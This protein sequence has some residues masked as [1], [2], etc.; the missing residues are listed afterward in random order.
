[1]CKVKVV[2][3]WEISYLPIRSLP[4]LMSPWCLHLCCYQLM[5]P[6]PERGAALNQSAGPT[7]G[8]EGICGQWETLAG[9]VAGGHRAPVC[10]LIWVYIRLWENLNMVMEYIMPADLL[11]ATSVGTKEACRWSVKAICNWVGS[12][13]SKNG[14]SRKTTKI[15]VEEYSPKV[16]ALRQWGRRRTR[17][18]EGRS[19]VHWIPHKPIS[20]STTPPEGEDP[21]HSAVC[22]ELFFLSGGN[23]WHRTVRHQFF[24]TCCVEKIGTF[25]GLYLSSFFF[26]FFFFFSSDK[27]IT[28]EPA[29]R[30][31]ARGLLY[32][33]FTL[34]W[35]A[36]S[37]NQ[38]DLD[39]DVFACEKANLEHPHRCWAY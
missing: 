20:L 22:G 25:T 30:H 6:S 21:P 38:S 24:L 31:P 9:R 29:L 12:E 10:D 17:R 1:M 7:R 39:A 4:T 19:Q 2:R 16:S 5:K 37:A 36:L 23:L 32:I 27:F 15:A 35:V 3:P 13:T 14:A 33:F 26:F 8:A 28:T 11:Y 34:F 18:V